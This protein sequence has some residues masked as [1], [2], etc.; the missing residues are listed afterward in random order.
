MTQSSDKSGGNI[1]APLSAA[2]AT[3]AGH[4][5]L[6]LEEPLIFELDAPG[7]TGVDLPEIEIGGNRLGGL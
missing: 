4:R 2:P 1:A 7:R 5:G 3:Y 6:D